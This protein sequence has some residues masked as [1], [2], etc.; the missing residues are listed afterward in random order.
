MSGLIVAWCLVGAAGLCMFAGAVILY[1]TFRNPSA[2][3]IRDLRADLAKA[4]ANIGQLITERDKKEKTCIGLEVD[5]TVERDNVT[6]LRR[7]LARATEQLEDAQSDSQLAGLISEMSMD[8]DRRWKGMAKAVRLGLV[9]ASSVQAVVTRLCGQLT[10][11]TRVA[12]EMEAETT[13]HTG[14]VSVE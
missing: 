13:E 5:I 14:G 7:R 3:I 10:D 6:R 1:V 8:H 9:E 4:L 2:A 11:L 12:D